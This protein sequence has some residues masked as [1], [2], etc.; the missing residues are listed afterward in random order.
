M[1]GTWRGKFAEGEVDGE[2]AMSNS[3]QACAAQQLHIKSLQR[4]QPIELKE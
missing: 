2:G 4:R 1:V 3:E